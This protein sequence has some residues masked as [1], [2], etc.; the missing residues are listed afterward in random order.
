MLVIKT[1]NSFVL[2]HQEGD[3]FRSA[4]FS[5]LRKC[6]SNICYSSL[7]FLHA[8]TALNYAMCTFFVSVYFLKV[9][10]FSAMKYYIVYVKYIQPTV[11]TNLWLL[12][13][14]QYL[15]FSL[16]TFS[17]VN[18]NINAICKK[19]AKSF[20]SQV[21]HG[22]SA[23]LR[24]LY[25]VKQFESLTPPGWETNPSQVSSQQMLVLIYV[26]QKDGKLS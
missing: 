26:T 13:L 6:Y 4:Q 9:L 15:L 17:C 19:L 22:A 25:S 20:T 2:L 10:F 5:F 14:A 16:I 21:A 24:F 7:V 1:G 12:Q 11:K 3:N 18:V 8:F 23:Y